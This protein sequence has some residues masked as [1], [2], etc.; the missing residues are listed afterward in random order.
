MEGRA[1]TLEQGTPQTRR[2]DGQASAN[3]ARP[4][5]LSGVRRSSPRPE[6]HSAIQVTLKRAFDVAGSALALLLLSPLLLLIALMIKVDS[7]GPILFRQQRVGR[8]GEPFGM[9]KF[10][11]MI[12]GADE[13]K[14]ALLHMNDAAD[15]LFKINNDPRVTRFGRLLRST[16]L[17]ELPQLL[18]VLS[19]RMSLV[20]PRPL[21]P[22]E[23]K[24]IHGDYRRRLEMRPG[25]TGAWQVAG[26]SQIPIDQMVKLDAEYV[27]SWTLL[28]DLRLLVGTIPH[29][30]RRRGI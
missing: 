18:H 17:D 9:R 19:G 27:E 13:H 10:R 5:G 29:V 22:N 14:L 11:T 21:V 7:P 15:G 26:A 23:D 28:H 20:G 25:I 2:G 16:S 24:L 8:K 30:L 6:S 3:G 12:V 4:E 1:R